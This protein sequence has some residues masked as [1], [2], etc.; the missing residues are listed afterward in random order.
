M[1]NP[2]YRGLAQESLV[3]LKTICETD[4][5]YRRFLPV[6][7]EFEE[8]LKHEDVLS[9]AVDSQVSG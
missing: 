3:I 4:T 7:E 1:F 8:E 5:Q 2:N 9:G 6:L